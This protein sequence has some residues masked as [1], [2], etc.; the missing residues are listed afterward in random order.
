[1]KNLVG[2]ILDKFLNISI[3]GFDGTNKQQ[4]KTDTSGVIQ[5]NLV[6]AALSPP[7][8]N[9]TFAPPA[10]MVSTNV[11][12]AITELDSKAARISYQATGTFNSTTGTTITHN[13]NRTN[14][15]VIL[16]STSDPTYVGNVY[17]TIAANTLTVFC[18]GSSTTASFA[19]TLL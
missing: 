6:G 19:V 10:D 11:Q 14:Y 15:S 8:T 7:A 3:Y 4:L 1:L 18:T 2:I 5:A 16:E 9:V 13:L 12:S 17:Y